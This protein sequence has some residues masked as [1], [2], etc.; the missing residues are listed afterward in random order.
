MNDLEFAEAKPIVANRPKD[1]PP[2]V[3]LLIIYH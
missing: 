1:I 2:D 3:Q